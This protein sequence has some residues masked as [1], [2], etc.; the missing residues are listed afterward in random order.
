MATKNAVKKTENKVDVTKAKASVKQAAKDVKEVAEVVV[1]KVVDEVKEAVAD[2]KEEV[3][4][5]AKKAAAKKEIKTS[6]YVQYLG[7]EVAEKDMIASV[8]K[9]WTKAGNKVGDI[10]TITLYVK[11]EES[12]VYYVINGTETGKVEF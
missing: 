2:A 10:K 4:Q 5:K 3:V 1:D 7:K 8:K 11:P 6:L 12:A 9:A